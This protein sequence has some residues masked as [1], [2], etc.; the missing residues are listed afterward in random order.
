[1]SHVTLYQCVKS[2]AIKCTE[3]EKSSNDKDKKDF[4]K[5]FEKCTSNASKVFE[6]KTK[7][8]RKPIK[9][10]NRANYPH[11]SS[12]EYIRTSIVIKSECSTILPLERRLGGC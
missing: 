12:E 3:I 9:H 7:V 5:I 4:H 2:V 10:K 8:P 6:T 11:E 1:M